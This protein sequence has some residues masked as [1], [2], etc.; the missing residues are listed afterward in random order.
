M[1]LLSRSSVKIPKLELFED[2]FSLSIVGR[3][4]QVKTNSFSLRLPPHAS[5]TLLLIQSLASKKTIECDLLDNVWCENSVKAMDLISS[6]WGLVPQPLVTGGF[7]DERP[8]SDKVGLAFSLGVD[9]MY[10]LFFGEQK[11]DYLIFV[12]GFD[13]PLEKEIVLEACRRSVREICEETGTQP[14]FVRT[15]LRENRFLKTQGWERTHGSA[16]AFVGHCLSGHISRFIISSTFSKKAASPW[17][18]H[19]DLDSLWSSGS[20]QIVHSGADIGRS[21]KL[22]RLITEPRSREIVSKHLRVCWEDP[23]NFGNCGKC[24]KCIRTRLELRKYTKDPILK[25]MPEEV[26][27]ITAIKDLPRQNP[28]YFLYEEAMDGQ[29]DE[30]RAVMLETLERWKKEA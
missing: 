30:V 3:P 26:S 24:Y 20:L 1:N 25:T 19:Y 18:S 16:L 8:F 14:I 17:G 4:I 27:L 2:Q 28:P 13:I 21:E 5:A 23:S 11:P 15:N 22:Q 7:Y 29:S 9:S 12:E 10:S 6:W